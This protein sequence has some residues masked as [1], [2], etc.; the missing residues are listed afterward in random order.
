MMMPKQ[1]QLEFVTQNKPLNIGNLYRPSRRLQLSTL[2]IVGHLA[3][4]RSK[5]C[6]KAAVESFDLR[7]KGRPFQ[8]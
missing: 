8:S 7:Q 3:Q 4:V 5:K 6:F 1:T 2:L